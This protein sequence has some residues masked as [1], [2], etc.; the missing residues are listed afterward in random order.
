LTTLLVAAPA[1]FLIH[2]CMVRCGISEWNAT[3]GTLTVMCSP[4]VIPAVASYITDIWALFAMVVCL[5]CCLRALQAETDR[6]AIVWIFC[7]A[8]GNAVT[9]TARQSAFLGVLVMVPCTL[10]LL[11][12]RPKVLKTGAFACALGY[13]IV[14]G[15]VIW[16][17][18]QP[19]TVAY[20]FRATGIQKLFRLSSF[21]RPVLE[22]PMLL[23]PVLVMFLPAVWQ[24]SRKAQ[25]GFI[26]GFS[27]LGGFS[28]IR[29]H[30]LSRWRIP[31]ITQYGSIFSKN[32][33]YVMWP[34]RGFQPQVIPEPIRFLVAL[35]TFL[36]LLALI[37]S[38]TG[39]WWKDKP[40]LAETG[41]ISW[42]NLAVLT[43]PFC[44][45]YTALL[46]PSLFGVGVVDRY[47]IPIAAVCM[48]L[49]LRYYEDR[50]RRT[51][52]RS[53]L[54]MVLMIAGYSVAAT[55]DSFAMYRAVLAAANELRSAGIPRNQIDAGWE[56]NGWTQIVEGGYIHQLG[57]RL[58]GGHATTMSP[59]SDRVCY[60]V[61]PFWLTEVHPLYTLS[62][63]RAACGGDA[64]FAPVTY[65]RWLSPHK[66]TVYVVKD[67]PGHEPEPDFD[68]VQ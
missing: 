36:G 66:M 26:A 53:I 52:P 2:R 25:A 24:S 33:S 6:S 44:L 13:A 67:P 41:Q 16:F 54:V 64:G 58:P 23:V 29:E 56:Y 61:I 57:V 34:I 39:D 55:H 38:F 17:S 59:D 43:V 18:H 1:T 40:S 30:S 48:L 65:N 51:L 45:A 10:W 47:E 28:L 5:Y 27:A 60:L 9:G 12:R 42:K 3:I 31:F 8:L 68:N 14:F 22:L 50:M 32:G 4:L 7:A 62:F 11:R 19:Y 20:G 21:I 15:A 49:L 37:V 35:A 46:V 63:D